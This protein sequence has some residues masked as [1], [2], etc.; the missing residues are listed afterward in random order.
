MSSV[1]HGRGSD[2]TRSTAHTRP[3]PHAT[4]TLILLLTGLGLTAA[5]TGPGDDAEAPT[6]ALRDDLPVPEGTEGDDDRTAVE[7]LADLPSDTTMV[8]AGARLGEG[9]AEA[10][11]D[12]P[13][14]PVSTVVRGETLKLVETRA[15]EGRIVDELPEGWWYPVEVLA[16]EPDRFDALVDHQVLRGLEPHQ[17]VLSETS[18]QVRGLGAGDLLE[19]ADGTELRV[20]A[21]LPDG[22]IGAAEV[23]VGVDSPLEVETE[24]FLLARPGD[25]QGRAALTELATDDREPRLVPHGTA[26]VLRHAH[27]VLPQVQ[28]K[29]HFGEFAMQQR[30]GRDIRPGQSWVDEHITVESVPILGRVRCH[31]EIFEPLRAA[32]HE[33][34][35]RGAQ[36][37]IDD[38]AGCWVPRTSGTTGPL[39]SHAW[40]ISI[41]FNAQANPYGA[42]PQQPDV[43]VEV[44]AEHG[45]LWGGDWDV[46]D[47]MHFE[48]APGRETGRN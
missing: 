16:F 4:L 6:G 45:F 8:W 27:G 29:A 5:L 17:A 9:Y 32:M 44:M 47:A 25:E 39:S 20:R 42:E 37:T 24:K 35:A 33:L 28:R 43:L 22:L 3:R 19:F 11:A 31:R 30:P 26:P 23:A 41:D 7:A 18:A 46:P 40:G 10:V 2:P 15:A 48:L 21:V 36:N 14:V 12:D 13:R 1:D 38:Y 34:E